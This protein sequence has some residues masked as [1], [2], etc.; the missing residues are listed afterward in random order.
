MANPNRVMANARRVQ[1]SDYAT[2]RDPRVAARVAGKLRAAGFKVRE[3]RFR[4]GPRGFDGWFVMEQD[5]VLDGE[6]N[7]E[8]PVRDV[9]TGVAYVRSICQSA[10]PAPAPA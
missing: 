10:V 6:P 5:T 9:R 4:M 8:G 1:A 2:F 3:S 7:G